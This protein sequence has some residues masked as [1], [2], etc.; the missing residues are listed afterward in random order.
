MKKTSL[1][2]P[3]LV[4]ATSSFGQTTD[5][6]KE[7]REM[8]QKNAAVIVKQDSADLVDL[9]AP[10][11]TINRT[12]GSVVSGR[13]TTQELFQKGIV[14]YDS[15]SVQTEHVLVKSAILAISMGS[16]VVTM[17]GNSS[18]KGQPVKRRFTHVWTKENSR[19]QLLAR[20]AN[21]ICTP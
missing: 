14:G 13:T 12:T 19:W 18:T 20:H 8:D 17:S 10:E 2:L 1:L 11:F 16:E 15:F 7:I 6:E 3:F 21:T 9:L 4:L 5:I